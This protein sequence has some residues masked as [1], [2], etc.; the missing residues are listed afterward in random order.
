MVR[1]SQIGQRGR[2]RARPENQR[3][4][5]RF[6]LREAAVDAAVESL[7]RASMTRRGLHRLVEHDR[8]SA[9]DVLAGDARRTRPRLRGSA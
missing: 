4:V 3:Q 7:I 8:Q 2:Q 6:L 5:L 1:S 9:A